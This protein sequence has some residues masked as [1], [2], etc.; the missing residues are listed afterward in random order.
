MLFRSLTASSSSSGIVN[1]RATGR[2]VSAIG[3]RCEDVID[4]AFEAEGGYRALGSGDGVMR[5]AGRWASGEMSGRSAMGEV[6]D[7]ICST[8]F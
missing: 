1:R 3:W 6:E 2:S 8:A 4:S 5:V 7:I